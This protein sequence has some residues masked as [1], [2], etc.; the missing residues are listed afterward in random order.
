MINNNFIVA[1][2]KKFK[3][4]NLN[5]VEI[6]NERKTE[7]HSNKDIDISKSGLNVDLLDETGSYRKRISDRIMR[8]RKSERKVRKDAVVLAEWVVSASPEVFEKISDENIK[9]YFYWA[10]RYFAD[11]FGGGNIVYAKIHFDETTPHM[12]L[13][14][15][16]LTKDGRLSAK[17]VFNR[18]ALRAVQSELPVFL[19]GKGFDV[20]RGQK[21][22]ERKKLTVPEYKKAQD[23]LAVLR[24]ENEYLERRNKAL[25][26]EFE[27]EI[28]HI[29]NTINSVLVTNTVIP[30][31]DEPLYFYDGIQKPIFLGSVRIF[32]N[33]RTELIAQALRPPRKLLKDVTVVLN[34]DNT[35]VNNVRSFKLSASDMLKNV[36][37]QLIKYIDC[38]KKS[39]R[40][41]LNA[42]VDKTTIGR[43]KITAEVAE[44]VDPERSDYAKGTFAEG[45]IL[46]ESNRFLFV[47]PKIG[48]LKSSLSSDGDYDYTL[49]SSRKVNRSR[50]SFLQ[51]SSVAKPN[52]LLKNFNDTPER[53]REIAKFY[54][55]KVRKTSQR[56]VVRR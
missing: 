52:D 54:K 25:E 6:H 12:H 16:P 43:A 10:T 7:K 22:N 37:E 55:P 27:R 32:L 14:L 2:M 33:T 30:P 34:K 42:S 23:D 26:V 28:S 24:K 50:A 39:L 31:E 8:N 53:A 18:S 21:N 35:P 11:K 4:E 49:T 13:G 29:T 17:D 44:W 48:E 20:R 15:V 5:G 47:N 45:N 56:N 3:G 9:L 51:N 38:W 1:T 46:G 19:K 40:R 36:R 41:Y